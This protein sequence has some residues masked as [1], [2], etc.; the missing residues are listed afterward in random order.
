MDQIAPQKKYRPNVAAIVANSAGLILACSRSDFPEC[1]QVPQGGLEA[2]ESPEEGLR[3]EL[4]EEIGVSS[5]E[6]I[7]KVP[8]LIRYDWPEEIQKKKG[9]HIGQEQHYFLVRLLNENEI[10]FDSHEEVEFSAAEWVTTDVFLS[11]LKH[12]SFKKAAIEEAINY[13]KSQGL[14]R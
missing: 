1:W 9:D 2:D 4:Q 3:R 5:I 10:R 6:I 13:F 7:A 11:R 12:A 14:L 8:H